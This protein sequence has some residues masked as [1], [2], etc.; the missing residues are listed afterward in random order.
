MHLATGESAGRLEI[1]EVKW[2]W[3]LSSDLAKEGEMMRIERSLL[4]AGAPAWDYRAGDQ[5]SDFR[6]VAAEVANWSNA[7]KTNRSIGPR[8]QS[9]L[10]EGR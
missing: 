4:Y 6:S 3:V 7:N 2:T 9:K 1:A 5:A 10:N 8:A